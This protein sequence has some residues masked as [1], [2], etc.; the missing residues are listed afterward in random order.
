MVC[1]YIS[2]QHAF[3][4]DINIYKE[5]TKAYN[6]K[7]SPKCSMSGNSDMTPSREYEVQGDTLD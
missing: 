5:V 6:T 7:Q 2:V 1:F 4:G 3:P